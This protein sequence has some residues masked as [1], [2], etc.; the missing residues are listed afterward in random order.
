M[1]YDERLAERVRA[2]LEG[3]DVREQKMF[4]GLT[5][6]VNGKMACG[7]VGDVLMVRVGKAA[8][9]DALARPHTRPMD[10][11]GRALGGMVY[12]DAPGVRTKRQLES[13]V[14]RG[15]AF[16]EG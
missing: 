11:T 10:F 14:A 8:H 2:V 15:V 5:F 13:W 12:V 4:G 9:A 6:M 1:A 16:V 7:V 3:R